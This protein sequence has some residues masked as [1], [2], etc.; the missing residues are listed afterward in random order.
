MAAEEGIRAD[1]TEHGIS[2]KLEPFVVLV[3]APLIGKGTVGQSQFEQGAVVEPV[4]QPV[5]ELIE[6]PQG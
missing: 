5:L 2:Q 4:A 6:L 3:E 1:Q